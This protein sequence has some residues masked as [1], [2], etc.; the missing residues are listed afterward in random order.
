MISFK[1]YRMFLPSP[2]PREFQ[3]VIKKYMQ[4][5]KEVEKMADLNPQR[6]LFYREGISEGC[7]NAGACLEACFNVHFSSRP[8]QEI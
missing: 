2:P 7:F 1:P 5:R 3:H 8:I 6:I 4:Y